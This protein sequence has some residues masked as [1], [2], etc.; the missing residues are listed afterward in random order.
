MEG[1]CTLSDNSGPGKITRVTMIC[2][3]L[4]PV[5]LGTCHT[6]LMGAKEGR[7]RCVGGIL[8]TLPPCMCP[9][10]G[11]CDG[12]ALASACPNISDMCNASNVTMSTE[13]LSKGTMKPPSYL[14]KS[15]ASEKIMLLYLSPQLCII[16]ISAPPVACPLLSLSL[17]G[18]GEKTSSA[19][20][21][22]FHGIRHV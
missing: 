1:L 21:W 18:G 16:C 19:D 22:Q 13:P 10:Q 6:L 5:G 7:N 12:A 9:Y 4:A 2:V 8:L 15:W 17:S 11:L 14:I 20:L 3:P